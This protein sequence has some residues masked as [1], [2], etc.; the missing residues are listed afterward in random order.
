MLALP[1]NETYGIGEGS[2][3]SGFFSEIFIAVG[4]GSL[5]DLVVGRVD[6]RGPAPYRHASRG[7]FQGCLAR[8]MFRYGVSTG[9]S[10][11]TRV[12]AVG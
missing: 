5:L 6:F 3:L 12:P 7:Y 10:T 9:P 2:I 1:R 11:G 4:A 8:C